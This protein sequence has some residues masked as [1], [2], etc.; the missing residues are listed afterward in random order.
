MS[1]AYNRAEILKA[2]HFMTRWRLAPAKRS[3]REVFARELAAERKKAKAARA[4]LEQNT[5]LP[6]RTCPA[7]V[8]PR[9]LRPTF[10][11]Y[12]SAR[13]YAGLGAFEAAVTDTAFRATAAFNRARA[14]GRRA[15]QW[16]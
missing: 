13:L 6:V 12:G 4:R 1:F 11:Q 16:I 7:D 2:A 3:Y 5:G 14:A 15:A 9:P 10:R 8:T